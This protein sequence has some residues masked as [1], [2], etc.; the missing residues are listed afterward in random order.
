M[1]V[2]LA[3]NSYGKSRVRLV[4]VIRREDRHDLKDLT[5]GIQLQG[6]F[7]TAHTAGDNRKILPTDTMK[8]TVYVM[9]KQSAPEE[10]EDFAQRLVAH[11]LE[12]NPQVSQA[13][14]EIVENLW[15]HTAGGGRPHPSAFLATG[16]KRTTLATDT[17]ERVS[18][19]SGLEG[20]RLLKTSG[21]AFEGFLRDQY[22]TL[23][24]THDR[25]LSTSVR[26]RWIYEARGIPFGE[27]WQGV[28]QT[29]IETFAGHQSQSVQHTLYAMGEAVLNRFPAVAEIHISMPNQHCLLVDLSAFQLENRNEIFMPVDEPHGHIEAALKRD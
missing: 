12:Q 23:K 13:R 29:L 3:A 15:E 26:A 11:F 16:E 19:E 8:N 7:E 17:R 20:L 27:Y 28:R 9:A 14:V 24:D 10:I 2:T 6:D 4:R 21:S 1:A 22:T 5:V 18:L 25:I